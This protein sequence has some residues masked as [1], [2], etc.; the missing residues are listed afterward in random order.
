MVQRGRKAVRKQPRLGAMQVEREV[1]TVTVFEAL[2]RRFKFV[3]RD[4]KLPKHAGWSEYQKI[5]RDLVVTRIRE[6]LRRDGELRKG[7]G[8]FS[9]VSETEQ[10]LC[11]MSEDQILRLRARMVLNDFRLTAEDK[12]N[13]K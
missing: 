12:E 8:L 7:S 1:S 13:A 3:D 11:Q 4:T 10:A 9:A 6:R 2:L 5:E